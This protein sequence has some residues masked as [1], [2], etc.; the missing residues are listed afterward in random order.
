[1]GDEQI[2]VDRPRE[3]GVVDPVEDVGDR[4]VLRENGLTHHG[5]GVGRLEHTHR[6]ARLLGE[7]L[8]DPFGDGERPM[9]HQYDL[10]GRSVVGAASR[11]CQSDECDEKP[12]QDP[13]H[14][15]IL[16]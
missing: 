9:G 16:S 12:S 14:D 5:S 10:I 13:T 7:R 15:E 4:I 6:D 3:E 8:E 2:L 1:M 11:Y